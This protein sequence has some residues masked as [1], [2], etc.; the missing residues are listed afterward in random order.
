MIQRTWRLRVRTYRLIDGGKYDRVVM[1]KGTT[2][3]PVSRR[4]FC[5]SFKTILKRHGRD[6]FPRT[7][8]GILW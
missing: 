2:K 8:H 1:R 6:L 4:Y 3:D 5:H 7:D